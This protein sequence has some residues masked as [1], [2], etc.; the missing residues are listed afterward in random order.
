[1]NI[2]VDE[3]PVALQVGDVSYP[4]NTDF[5]YALRVILAFEDDELT[6]EE[7]ASVMLENIF[8][9]QPDDLREA[10][11]VATKFLNGAGQDGHS[12]E[13]Q[14]GPR[15]YS[16]M[17]DSGFIFA[18]FKQTH[19]IDLDTA[20][21]H[22]WKFMALFLDLGSET[23]FC[24]IVSLRKRVKTGKATKE[25]KKEFRENFELYDLPETDTRSLEEKMKAEEFM[26]LVK[27]G[28]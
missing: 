27:G 8:Q 18:A 22:W 15:V 6:P 2:L 20:K 11:K 24:Q 28:R 9:E 7:K 12:A 16:F 1:M 10:V 25:E 26:R 13:G 14:D 3:L 23:T 19:G 21:M 4:I 17:K 5:R